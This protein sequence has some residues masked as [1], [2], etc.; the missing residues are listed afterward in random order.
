MGKFNFNQDEFQKVKDEAE[1]LYETFGL[2]YCPYF[3]EKISLPDISFNKSILFFIV[4][5]AA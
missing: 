4:L 2:I 1:K 5:F 3:E